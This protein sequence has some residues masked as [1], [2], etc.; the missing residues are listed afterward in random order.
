MG[1]SGAVNGIQPF[2]ELAQSA[3][4]VVYKGYD[5][6]R[7][8]FV[9]LK[10]LQPAFC[11][12]NALIQRF[13]EEARLLTKVRHPNVVA[14]YD[15]GRDEGI[16][17]LAAEFVDGINLAELCAMGP[18][19]AELALYI[20]LQAAEGLKASHAEGILHRD[21]KPANILVS[22]EGR[23]KVADFGMASLAEAEDPDADLAAEEVRGTLA[24]LAPEQVLGASPGEAADLFSLGATFYELLTGRPAF[25]GATVPDYFDAVVNHDPLPFLAAGPRLPPEAVEICS[26]LL[27][28][29][30]GARYSGIEP[31]L[32]DLQ[33][34]LERY[35]VGAAELAAYMSEPEAYRK[36]AQSA[37]RDAPPTSPVTRVSASAPTI[38][39]GR[40]ASLLIAALAFV[41]WGAYSV[42]NR[43]DLRPASPGDLARVTTGLQ[44]T[45]ASQVLSPPESVP[46]PVPDSTI[47]D[48]RSDDA[49][50]GDAGAETGI[51]EAADT[52]P[53][54]DEIT[55]PV[56]RTGTLRVVS[57]PWSVVYVNEDSVGVTP[58][59]TITPHEMPAGP[60][61]ITLRPIM[62]DFPPYHTT[63]DINPGQALDV[64]VSLWD[65]VGR[66]TFQVN[67]WAR[68]TVDEVD[69][70]DT[71]LSLIL[72]PGT[73][74]LALVH[75]QLGRFEDTFTVAAGAVD[76]LRY[77][78]RTM[79]NH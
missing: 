45:T 50:S 43:P 42:L 75:P 68:V 32:D 70:D 58:F 77:N 55:A 57:E 11:Q 37:P 5:R 13:E 10:V 15:F 76:T 29:S 7:D 18:V 8:R 26:R 36:R 27:A 66:I 19:P 51:R 67:P 46:F 44:D 78:L 53:P 54:T 34:L 40:R 16:V 72:A 3:T 49:P 24:Y 60:Y 25:T 63:I 23:V 12:D 62:P 31:L 48:R 71:P 74:K 52:P 59:G 38:H 39:R 17:F 4:T 56:P 1:V 20:L 14:I 9:L 30:P 6:A 64:H 79:Q 41:S 2:A 28:K 65:T 69:R 47:A 73:H 61:D 22:I 35:C 33:P 21:I